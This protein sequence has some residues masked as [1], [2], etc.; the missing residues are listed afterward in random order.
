MKPRLI[1]QQKITAFANQYRVFGVE[2]AGARTGLVAFAQQK[3]LAFKERVDFYN[4]EQKTAVLFTFR[5]EKVIDVHGR[6]MVEDTD[7][8]LL[9]SFKKEFKQSLINSTWTV[10][11]AA[12]GPKY[13]VN[14]SSMALALFRRFGGFIP[15][16][17]G[18]ADLIAVLLKFHFV[19]TD[20]ATGQAVGQYRKTTL[21]RDHYELSMTDEGMQGA[22]WRVLS[23]MCVG[24]DALQS[25]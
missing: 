20:V 18:F 22:D 11:D 17:G 1:V 6:Y 16:I 13:V 4:S 21:L 15:F 5:A 3:R 8:T 10:Y 24:L 12:N 19:F 23:A 7:G 9:G 2:E 14:E 25:R